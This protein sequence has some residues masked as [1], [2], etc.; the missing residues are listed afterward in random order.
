MQQVKGV[1]F[2]LFNTLIT[3]EAS[4]LKDAL[5]RLTGSLRKSGF[6]IEHHPFVKAHSE[7]VLR[8]LEQSKRDGRESHNRFW[9]SDALTKLGHRVSPDEPYISVAVETYFSAFI[10]YAEVIPGTREMLAAIQ[11]RY[12]IGLLSNFT[13]PPAATKII[14]DLGL[15]PFFDTILISGDLGYRKPHPSV[16]RKL[17]KE[18]GVA[19]NEI[20]FVG[21]DPEADVGGAL[22]AGLKPIWATYIW[23]NNILPAPG[24]L[25]PAADEPGPA[26]PRISNWQELLA[27]LDGA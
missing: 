18:L 8:F 11:G 21:D 2:D 9:I 10:Q 5:A 26:V 1:G 12:R 7:A 15:A 6:A 22:Q 20:A 25:G 14:N 16:F 19:E 17:I 24:M 4:A 27:L 3:M 13:H 23:D